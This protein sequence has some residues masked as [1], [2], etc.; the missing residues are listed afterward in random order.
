M[1][2]HGKKNIVVQQTFGSVLKVE[3]L[4][5]VQN[6]PRRINVYYVCVCVYIYIYIQTHTHT[7]TIYIYIYIRRSIERK[8]RGYQKAEVYIKSKCKH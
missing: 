6:F 1:S 8:L 3:M 4:T 7:H 5:D 2:Y